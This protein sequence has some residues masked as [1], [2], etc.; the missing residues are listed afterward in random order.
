MIL[1]KWNRHWN[2][3]LIIYSTD[4]TVHF[5]RHNDDPQFLLSIVNDHLHRLWSNHSFVRFTVV[6]C[7]NAILMFVIFLLFV[8]L[9]ADFS[10][11]RTFAWSISWGV[12]VH[13]CLLSPSPNHVSIWRGSGLEFR[14]YDA[15]LRY[16]ADRFVIYL[17]LVGLQ[18][19]SAL[20]ACLALWWDVL[21][22]LQ[23]LRAQLVRYAPTTDHMI[24]SDCWTIREWTELE[25]RNI[26]RKG[27]CE[28]WVLT[29]T[30]L[31]W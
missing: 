27:Y 18:V 16:C 12:G 11:G 23:F 22:C 17:W 5:H 2:V 3:I 30:C 4:W 13:D 14:S 19:R 6:G 20:S 28:D 25:R 31:N 21:G 7:T 8:N 1:L 29:S 10:H 9:L 26:L 15:H 24:K